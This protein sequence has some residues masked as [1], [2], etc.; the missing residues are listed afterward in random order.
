MP[1]DWAPEA[2]R[3]RPASQADQ[4]NGRERIESTEKAS[5]SLR[6]RGYVGCES[7]GPVKV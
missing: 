6:L 3:S 2:P 4:S 1:F 5:A 7:L